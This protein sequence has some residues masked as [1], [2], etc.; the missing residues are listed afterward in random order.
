MAMEYSNRGH[1]YLPMRGGNGQVTLFTWLLPLL[2]KYGRYTQFDL[3]R[4]DVDLDELLSWYKAMERDGSS[5]YKSRVAA[6]QLLKHHFNLAMAFFKDHPRLRMRLIKQAE[7][8]FNSPTA[9]KQIE[10]SKGGCSKVLVKI[11]KG[12]T[13]NGVKWNLYIFA[14]LLLQC[15]ADYSLATNTDVLANVKRV[16]SKSKIVVMRAPFTTSFINLDVDLGDLL[17]YRACGLIGDLDMDTGYATYWTMAYGELG[18]IV[19][20]KGKKT[21]YNKGEP[22][23]VLLRDW[24]VYSLEAVSQLFEQL[25]CFYTS[26]ELVLEQLEPRLLH[27][28]LQLQCLKEPLTNMRSSAFLLTKQ[29][30]QRST[31]INRLLLKAN[32]RM[33]IVALKL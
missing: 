15:I 16:F 22:Y 10:S 13:V 19:I 4:I 27:S 21:L 18:D 24:T 1:L 2:N 5:K 3:E 28:M 30:E 17:Y 20:G 31:L 14:R 26:S 32:D 8:F 23:L 29:H 25:E 11:A 33:T 9:L 12:S 7:E 6:Q